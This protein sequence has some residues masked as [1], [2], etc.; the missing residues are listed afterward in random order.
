MVGGGDGRPLTARLA[1]RRI[2]SATA[3]RLPGEPDSGVNDEKLSLTANAAWRNRVYAA[4]G[5]RFNL[6]LGE[7]D[8]EQLLVKLRTCRRASG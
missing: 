4:G 6:L 5:A 2:W 8:D 1:Y 3:D 7:F